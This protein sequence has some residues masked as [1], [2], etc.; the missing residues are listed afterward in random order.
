MSWYICIYSW[1]SI[2]LILD[3]FFKQLFIQQISLEWLTHTE[4]WQC[5]G[6]EERHSQSSWNLYSHEEIHTEQVDRKTEATKCYRTLSIQRR[7]EVEEFE[8]EALQSFTWALKIERESAKQKAGEITFQTEGLVSAR[9]LRWK[10]AWMMFQIEPLLHSGQLATDHWSESLYLWHYMQG[11]Y[12]AFKMRLKRVKRQSRVLSQRL[13]QTTRV[14][15]RNQEINRTKVPGADNAERSGTAA[16]E[17]N[18]VH[19][20]PPAQSCHYLLMIT[21]MIKARCQL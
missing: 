18:S 6:V 14:G 20:N 15:S 1:F 10:I 21:T 11:Q 8:G 3:D 17:D 13:R 19:T 7:C 4:Y 5:N 12:Q 2:L 16:F 9:A